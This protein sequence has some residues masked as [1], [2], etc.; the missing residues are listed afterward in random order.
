MYSAGAKG[1]WG[2]NTPH[3]VITFFVAVSFCFF[4][5]SIVASMQHPKI[6]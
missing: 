3:S 1:L 5:Q 4:P 2:Q 6:R